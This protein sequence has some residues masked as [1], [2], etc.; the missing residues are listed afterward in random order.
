M[1][2]TGLLQQYFF[3]AQAPFAAAGFKLHASH[4]QSTCCGVAVPSGC[5]RHFL[6][7]EA[8]NLPWIS[9]T[10]S[11]TT[12][13]QD[14]ETLARDRPNG[15]GR[16]SGGGTWSVAVAWQN[17]SSVAVLTFGALWA[18]PGKYWIHLYPFRYPTHPN[19]NIELL[20]SNLPAFKLF[21]LIWDLSQYTTYDLHWETS[22]LSGSANFLGS[23]LPV[24]SQHI[25]TEVKGLD[26]VLPRACV[27]LP[28][29]Q[30]PTTGPWLR[31]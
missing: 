31:A 8:W 2:H 4:C 11:A 24:V 12:Q 14:A 22:S 15:S 9:T 20:Q 6:L 27:N 26:T 5:W 17:G 18:Q 10:V 21:W 19:F 7:V 23:L 3:A 30:A 13:A 16:K 25:P 29:L 28:S 1:Q